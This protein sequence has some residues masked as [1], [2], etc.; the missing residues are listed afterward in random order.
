MSER[1]KNIAAMAIFG[2]I[3]VFVR[4]IPMPS[5][6]ISLSRAAIGGVF[7]LILMLILGKRLSLSSIKENA[8]LLLLSGIA[9]GFNWMLLF[10]A[11]KYTSV[12]NATLCY[13]LAPVI[14]VVLSP[15][16]FKEG[17]TLTRVLAV[18]LSVVGMALISGAEVASVGQRGVIGIILGISAACLY[19][20]IVILNKKLCGISAY[21]R[22]AVQL[23]VSA[24]SMLPYCAFTGA[25][26][27]I[28]LNALQ[29]A[30]VL[31]LGIVHTGVAYALYFG[32]IGN[33][34]AQTIALLGYI[35]PVL[36]LVLSWTLLGEGFTLSGLVGSVLIL[37]SMLFCEIW[38]GR[39]QKVPKK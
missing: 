34:P 9:L 38:E 1:I 33:L 5:S 36:A 14:M 8:I 25:F 17:L 26:P 6:V 30:I 21:E 7:L 3:G 2:S 22:T 37:G 20:M 31:V 29:V 23:I 13:Y 32:S 4:L 10:E 15:L 16:I 18:I 35:D 28:T 11:Y 19:A 12:A 24:I 27:G 39:E